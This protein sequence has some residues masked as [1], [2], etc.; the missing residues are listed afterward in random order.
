MIKHITEHTVEIVLKKLDEKNQPRKEFKKVEQTQ[1]NPFTREDK[2]RLLTIF[3]MSK[4]LILIY[5]FY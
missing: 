3:S 2:I 5:F 1:D 4:F